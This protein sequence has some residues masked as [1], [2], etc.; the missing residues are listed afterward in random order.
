MANKVSLANADFRPFFLGPVRFRAPDRYQIVAN[1]INPTIL[2]ILDYAK[3]IREASTA[4]KLRAV[5]RYQAK[6]D[7]Y[8]RIDA[9]YA[10]F[11]ELPVDMRRIPSVQ[12]L[13]GRLRDAVTHWEGTWGDAIKGEG[14]GMG[15]VE[16][17]RWLRA[18]LTKASA[19]VEEIW[20]YWDATR[21]KG[22]DMGLPEQWAW[23]RQVDK[24]E[25]EMVE[26]WKRGPVNGGL[27]W[28][29][30]WVVRRGIEAGLW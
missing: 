30:G 8:P 2:K 23:K 10:R 25:K 27:P 21:A 19:D 5:L 6:N 26:A 7:I 29:V 13:V 4:G 3:D 1:I 18:R 12:R 24:G 11:K 15:R 16:R 9:T 14:R 17:L 28:G 22:E 20:G